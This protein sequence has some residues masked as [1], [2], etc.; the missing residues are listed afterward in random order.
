MSPNTPF[1]NVAHVRRV[2][3]I[4]DDVSQISPSGGLSQIAATVLELMGL[5]VPTNMMK[6][7]ILEQSQHSKHHAA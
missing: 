6:S 2:V 1:D 4:D 5:E 7:L 3:V